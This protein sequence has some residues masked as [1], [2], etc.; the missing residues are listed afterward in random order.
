MK[1]NEI[2]KIEAHN[3][4]GAVLTYWNFDDEPETCLWLK[5]D[6]GTK[7]TSVTDYKHFKL[8]FDKIQG[9]GLEEL[10]ADLSGNVLQGLKVSRD[11]ELYHVHLQL[12][13]DDSIQFRC[14]KVY[15]WLKHYLGISYKN[16]YETEEFQKQFEE[17]RYVVAPEYFVEQERYELPDGYSLEVNTYARQEAQV[18]KAQM[19]KCVLKHGTETVYEYESIYNHVRPFTE[20]IEHSNG[21]RYYPF[22]IDLYGISFLELD[23]G[24][25]YHYVPQGYDNDWGSFYGESFIIT[26]IHYDAET[27]LIAYGGCYWA[28]PNDVMVGDF[29]EPL[30]FNPKLVNLHELIDPD[31]EEIDDVDFVRWEKDALVVQA[32]LK[33]EVEIG[34]EELRSCINKLDRT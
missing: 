16:V 26:D 6:L 32:D 24:K 10:E 11:G 8:S 22:H 7:E 17:S 14:E 3:F 29:S 15:C 1:L 31:Y 33:K 2:E 13:G 25:V 30:H 9:E 12:H 27:D 19:D 20:F 18:V 5:G 28:A 23:T 34:L 21:H 4:E